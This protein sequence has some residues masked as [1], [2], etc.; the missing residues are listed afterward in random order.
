MVNSVIKKKYYPETAA[1][2]CYY[3][4][5]IIKDWPPQHKYR[6]NSTTKNYDKVIK[7]F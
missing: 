4:S 7:I 3:Y 1:F 2:G 6:Y 5:R